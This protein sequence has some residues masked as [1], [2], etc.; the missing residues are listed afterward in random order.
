M[1]IVAVG[2]AETVRARVAL[3]D[4]LRRGRE[5]SRRLWR[6]MPIA[7]A[8]CVAVAAGARWTGSSPLLPLGLL[9]IGTAALAGYAYMSRRD[10]AISDTAAAEIDGLAGLA[11]ELR[12]A[13]WFSTRDAQDPFVEFHLARAADRLQAVD[14][15][16]LYPP[17]RAHRAK[18]ATALLTIGA[19]ALALTVPGRDGVKASTTITASVRSSSP[20]ESL[21]A[22]LQKQLDDLLKSAERGSAASPGRA[23][24]AGEVRDLLSRLAKAQNRPTAKDLNRGGDLAEKGTAPSLKDLDDSAE[25]VR[26]AAEMTSLSPEV[27]DALSEVADKLTEMRNAESTSPRDPQ[28]AMSSADVPKGGA[29]QSNRDSHKEEASIQAVK[30]ASAGGGVGV[31]MMASDDEQT[32]HEAGLGLGGGSAANNGRGRMADIGAALK[33]ETIEAHADAAGENIETLIRRKTE[34]GTATVGYV[35]APAAAF[36]R[37]RSTAPPPVPESRRAAVQTYFIRKP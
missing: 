32:S 26:R 19:L 22:D 16:Q 28:D 30:D 1:P 5:T 36:D 3:A 11:G 20:A 17:V 10:R 8:I 23:L 34:S 31:I 21:P 6:A 7:A 15:T 37:G 25:R 18:A 4:R 9:G 27:R 35:S 33:K 14:W 2:P 13:N 12:S 29:A 24:T